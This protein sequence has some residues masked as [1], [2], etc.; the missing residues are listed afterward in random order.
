MLTRFSPKFF[1]WYHSEKR[2]ARVTRN[3]YRLAY[4]ALFEYCPRL[5]IVLDDRQLVYIHMPKSACTSIKAT[6]GRSYGIGIEDGNLLADRRWHT[7]TRVLPTSLK[8]YHRFTFVRDPFSRL[9][10]CYADKV[11]F[12][13]QGGHQTY[14]A[15][16]TC[17]LR[18]DISFAGF[19]RAVFKIPDR[20]ADH[21]IKSQYAISHYRGRLLADSVGYLE[22]M[23]RDWADLAS[24][25]DL[26][27]KIELH[28][29][30]KLRG[31]HKDY[32]SIYTL[33]LAELVYRRY[34]RDFDAFGYN[35]VY[36][37]L[38]E[39]LSG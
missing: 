13:R 24:R 23:E 3:A 27:P 29:S 38:L 37:K 14:L 22:N 21:H 25:F 36:K 6:I 8:H 39:T 28:R 9:V 11:L 20:L 34:R 12:R 2:S 33:E 16:P 17:P 30:A 15:S 26:K 7:E 10:S 18:T 32:H 31:I 35:D 5:F 1:H 4:F 19:V